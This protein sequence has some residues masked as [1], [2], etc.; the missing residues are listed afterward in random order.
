LSLFSVN[1]YGNT[2]ESIIDIKT[3][4]GETLIDGIAHEEVFK[5]APDQQKHL[6]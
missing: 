6:R 3:N 1:I 2:F 5:T 4:H